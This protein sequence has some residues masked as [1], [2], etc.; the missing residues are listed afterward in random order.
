M[1]KATAI[2]VICRGEKEVCCDSTTMENGSHIDPICKDCCKCNKNPIWEGK[3]VAGGA[4][5]RM[6]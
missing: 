5:E 6:G 3:C 1:T 2:C 4:Y